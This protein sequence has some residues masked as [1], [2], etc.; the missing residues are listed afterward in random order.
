MKKESRGLVLIIN[1]ENFKRK[2][3]PR[4]G[5]QIDVRRLGK[6]FDD[7]NFTVTSKFH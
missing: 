1:N 3:E 5:S 6:V 4:A 7:L 2:E